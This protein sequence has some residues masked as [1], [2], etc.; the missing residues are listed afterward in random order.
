MPL[1]PAAPRALVHTRVIQMN[2]YEREDG[3]W[4]IE[5]HLRDTKTFEFENRE[6]GVLAPGTPVHDMWLRLTIDE[7]F[8][9]H[10]AV[11]HMDA[12]PYRLCPSITP[13]FEKLKGLRVG[14]GWNRKV[15]ELLGGVRGCTHLVEM[16]GPMA[17]VAYQ[18]IGSR[19]RSLSAR[20]D[21]QTSLGG[22]RQPYFINACHTW[23]TNSPVVKVEF[24]EFYT[25][26][27]DA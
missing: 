18:S 19:Q 16:L 26:D 21:G 20:R 22:G 11:A 2:G 24:P 14:P 13:S 5:G 6:R 12:H 15:K 17:T 4:D 1:P 10:D 9:V 7:D 25:G 3:L 27:S 8:Y 23:A